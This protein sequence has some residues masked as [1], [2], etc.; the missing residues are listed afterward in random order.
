MAE[1]LWG[2]FVEVLQQTLD[3]YRALLRLSTYK[4]EVLIAADAP[5]LEQLTRQ[6]E[7]LVLQVAKMEPI[8]KGI[9][10]QLA[11]M[12]AIS[13][14]ELTLS[15][16]VVLAPG[17]VADRLI[18]IGKEF[19]GVSGELMPLN[20]SNARLIEQALTFVNYTVNLLTRNMAA[21]TYAPQGQAGQSAAVRSTIDQKA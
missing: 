4:R 5:V 1:A 21:P 14:E 8:R 19:E 11:G 12:Y 13:P 15:K 10:S 6:E 16:A 7:L 9:Q 3:L 17:P 2:N 20:R 18:T